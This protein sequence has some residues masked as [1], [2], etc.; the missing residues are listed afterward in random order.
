MLCQHKSARGFWHPTGIQVGNTASDL[1]TA[2]DPYI[3]QGGQPR[4]MLDWEQQE[5]TQVAPAAPVTI[6]GETPCP[7]G[8]TAPCGL[9]SGGMAPAF[10]A[11]TGPLAGGSYADLVWELDQAIWAAN[12]GTSSFTPDQFTY[13]EDHR[14]GA[15]LANGTDRQQ[16]LAWNLDLPTG[17]AATHGTGPADEYG[18]ADRSATAFVADQFTYREDHRAGATILLVSPYDE[19]GHLYSEAPALAASLLLDPTRCDCFA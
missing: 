8:G 3:L 5:R 7:L 9:Q 14:S 15:V 11:S 4:A 6:M 18:Q 10:A 1:G 2:F 13:R 17:G 12:N 19:F 16:F